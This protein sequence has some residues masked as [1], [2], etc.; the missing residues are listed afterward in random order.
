MITFEITRSID[1]EI[2]GNWNYQKNSLLIGHTSCKISDIR[3]A[4]PSVPIKFIKLS[5]IKNLL[6]L[7][8]LEDNYQTPVMINSKR[9]GQKG[10]C[11]PGDQVNIGN[12]EIK[13]I[14]FSLSKNELSVVYAEN[15]KKMIKGN[16]PSLS[17]L[18]TLEESLKE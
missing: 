6:L 7:E 1:F 17:I 8:V 11:M 15:L 5:I 16:H 3:I 12:T 18:N 14:D 13:I 10:I 4:D 9:V 2:W